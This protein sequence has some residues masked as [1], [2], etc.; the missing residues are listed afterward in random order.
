MVIFCQSAFPHSSVITRT[1]ARLH[2]RPSEGYV[3][4]RHNRIT[5]RPKGESRESPNTVVTKRWVKHV[6]R[7]YI[8]LLLVLVVLAIVS[9]WVA[10][11]TSTRDIERQLTNA[12]S[13]QHGGNE[14]VIE[15]GNLLLYL[16]VTSVLFAIA[17]G[18]YLLVRKK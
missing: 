13:E 15:G 5:V 10:S 12:S 7:Q 14:G 11:T 4:A 1:T 2:S 17:V 16:S 8:A 3:D 18:G 6:K 9:L